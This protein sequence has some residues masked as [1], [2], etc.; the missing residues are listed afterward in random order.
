MKKLKY[1]FILI[2]ALLVLSGIIIFF[3]NNKKTGNSVQVY[4]NNELIATYPLDVDNEYKIKNG[5]EYNILK[6]E[7]GKA[8]II[9]ASCNN[10]ICV[11]HKCVCKDGEEIICVPNN[12]IIRIVSNEKG[13]VDAV[14]K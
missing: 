10:Q 8:R 13:D 11:R 6:I 3:M 2:F 5:N 7:N 14:A 9:K 4:K 12:I 1:D